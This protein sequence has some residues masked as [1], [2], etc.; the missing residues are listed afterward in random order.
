MKLP[1][2]TVLA[3][4]GNFV[5]GFEDKTQRRHLRKRGWIEYRHKSWSLTA[6][7]RATAIREGFLKAG[8][9]A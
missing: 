5:T 8:E 9:S 2:A 3:Y 4:L 6:T 7:G 1:D